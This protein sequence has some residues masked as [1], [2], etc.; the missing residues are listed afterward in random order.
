M[1]GAAPTVL[2]AGL[3]TAVVRAAEDEQAVGTCATSGPGLG[4]RRTIWSV[5][6]ATDAVL[7]FDDGP[8][9]ELTPGLLDV[10]ARHDVRAT[11]MVIGARA[12]ERPDLI[13]RARDEGHEIGNH[14][15]S[16]HSLATLDHHEV[17]RE[18]SRTAELIGEAR[19]F[20]PPRGV[21]TGA[22]AQVAAEHG[23]DTLMWSCGAGH[24]L[25]PGMVVC[26]HDGLGRAGFSH[27]APTAR[28]M[29]AKRAAELAVLPAAI[30]RARDA[31]VRF[32]TMSDLVR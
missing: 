31:G 8:D 24:E 27:W 21:L 32:V 18:L 1:V 12:A 17:R 20:R 26:M 19:F 6:S 3:G 29:R 10:L 22:A 7:T 25:R 28:H 23:Y 5:D 9:P 4:I 16:H 2:G 30:E 15:W 14:T 13:R 11:F